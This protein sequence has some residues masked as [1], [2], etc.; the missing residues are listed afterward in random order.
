MGA[1]V[2]KTE[3]SAEDRMRFR[4]EVNQEL[5][6]FAWML[7]HA[8][9]DSTFPKIGLEL[10]LNL[11]DHEMQPSMSNDDVLDHLGE[12][13][14]SELAR[15]NIEVNVSPRPVA[16]GASPSLEH[17]V[18]DH[19]REAEEAA[20]EAGCRMVPIGILPTLRSEHL[21]GEWISR[22]ARYTALEKAIL[23]ERG[24][25][26]ATLDITGPTGE[27]IE[28][29]V[30]DIA[31]A[32][33]C[34]SLQMHRQVSPE[35]FATFWNAAQLVSAVQVAVGANSPFLFG[36]RLWAETRIPLFEQVLDTRTPELRN[37]NVRSRAI[38]GRDWITS[39]AD[40]FRENIG[41]YP[42]LLPELFELPATEGGPGSAHP[43]NLKG[44]APE[45]PRLLLH[46]GTVWRWNRGIY[47]VVDGV[48]HLRVENRVLPAGPTAADTLAN[49]AL[50]YGLV[51]TLVDQSPHA[52]VGF[53]HAEA[54]RN[55][56][57]AA[58]HGLDAKLRWPG[59]TGPVPVTQLVTEHLIPL[60][61][62][63]LLSGGTTPEDADTYLG[64]VRRRCEKGVN[65]AVWQTRAVEQLE[66]Q[67]MDR[68]AALT[69]MTRLYWEN[70]ATHAP[71]DQW[72]LPA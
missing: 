41:S 18:L 71:V 47:D 64:T 66:G 58:E 42:A 29:Y 63:G 2:E 25:E 26:G 27:R 53:A 23:A 44:Q 16:T 7:A 55:F 33:A 48:P 28:M 15:F 70:N 30:P 13:F 3:Y 51:R 10:E 61:R 35:N 40:L 12:H 50:Y 14:Q 57:A 9:F 62:A 68:D 46:N 11:V 43:G 37:Q 22:G 8:E 67:G 60:A 24:G 32:A 39:P 54:E 36:K 52:W 49:C 20:A 17:V 69:E 56:Y 59:F 19:L 5:E 4:R 31:P 21:Q 72:P 65:G 6:T 34:T 1:E 45:L 38:F